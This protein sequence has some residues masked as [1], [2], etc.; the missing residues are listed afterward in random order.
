ML[1]GNAFNVVRIRK[2]KRQGEMARLA[3]IDASYLASIE[4]GRR[5]APSRDVIDKLLPALCLEEP[6]QER[7]R[8]L[9][10]IDRMLDVIEGQR[11]DDALI[12]RIDKLLRQVADFDE[13]D[14]TCLEWSASTIAHL[15]H[16]RRKGLI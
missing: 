4:C 2:Q 11:A 1:F 3:G 8:A 12:G 15:S 14:W 7:L 5:K 16:Q 10:V 13:T 6:Q 9:A